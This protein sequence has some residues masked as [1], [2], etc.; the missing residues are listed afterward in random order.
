MERIG[1]R[2]RI[3]TAAYELF[4]QR[5]IARVSMDDIAAHAGLTKRAVYYHVRSKDDLI[6]DA[7]EVHQTHLLREFQAWADAA[8][9]DGEDL[10]AALFAQLGAWA[11]RPRWLGSGFS[12]VA[13]ELADLPGH[14]ARRIASAHKREIETWLA[15]RLGDTGHRDAEAQARKI[16]ILI[17]GG[18]ALALIHGDADY[19]ASA[20]AAAADVASARP[21]G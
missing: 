17:E 13:L 9:A 12:R 21:P 8:E 15:A 11:R 19:L 6:A 20:A 4:Y 3:L 18:M 14:P 16:M 7:F 5:G 2:H 10:V 1:T